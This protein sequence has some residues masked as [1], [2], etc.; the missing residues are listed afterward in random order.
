MTDGYGPQTQG[1]ARLSAL[2]AGSFFL[3]LLLLLLFLIK[4]E[5]K[6]RPRSSLPLGLYLFDSFL[7][8]VD[9]LSPAPLAYI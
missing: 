1:A 8:V 2:Q 4:R 5:F 6:E 9:A 3:L 7:K